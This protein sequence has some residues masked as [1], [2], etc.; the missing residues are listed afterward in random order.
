MKNYVKEIKG[1]AVPV[2]AS[3]WCGSL[4]A[5]WID[6]DFISV[7]GLHQGATWTDTK[8]GMPKNAIELPEAKDWSYNNL[9]PVGSTCEFIHPGIH[10]FIKGEVIHQLFD[11]I[12]FVC[13]LPSFHETH[14]IAVIFID[15]QLKFRPLK[16]AKDL[17]REAFFAAVRK[18]FEGTHVINLA[19]ITST[20]FDADFKAPTEKND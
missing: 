6:N 19:D 8:R 1:F 13:D 3:H 15:D 5:K 20:L 7:I 16:S 10:S 12:V 17:E 9:P 2:G 4:F 11:R 18:A 14:G